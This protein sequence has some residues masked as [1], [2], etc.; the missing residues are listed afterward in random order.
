MEVAGDDFLTSPRLPLDQHRALGRGNLLGQPHH[1]TEDAR[2]AKRLDFAGFLAAAD[3]L[4]ELLVLGAEAAVFGG[5]AAD[6]HHVVV[7]EGLLY[8]VEGAFVDRL[9]RGLQRCLRGHQD[10]G[11]LRILPPHCRQDLDAGHTGHLQIRQDDIG[12]GAFELL[13]ARFAAL[14][15]RDVEA[16]ILEQD[17]Q[18]FENALLVV[19]DEN[20]WGGS[21]RHYAASS[22]RRAAGK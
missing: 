3:F 13:Q 2:F 22:L 17:P 1:L 9:N 5:A 20:R 14:R 10:H 7:G 16:F 8:I 6:R 4:L 12:R 18:R 21:V 15:D 11:R 19:D